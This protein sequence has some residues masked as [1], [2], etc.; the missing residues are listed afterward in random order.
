MTIHMVN[1]T[2]PMMMKG[3]L[4]EIVP[5]P[6]QQVSVRVPS[7]RRIAAV[8]LLVAGGD[9]QYRESNGAVELEVPSIGLHEVVAIE[10]AL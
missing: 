7:G 3:P 9:V 5:I 10:F 2:N 8:R 4:R 6:A 1:L